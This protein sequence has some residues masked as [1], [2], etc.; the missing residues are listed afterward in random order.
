MFTLGY[1]RNH[2]K[3]NILGIQA[4]NEKSLW[5]Q[6]YENLTDDLFFFAEDVFG[7]QFAIRN[8][9]IVSFD[10]ESGQ[11][12]LLAQSLEGWAA[13]LLVNYPRLTGYPLAHSWQVSNGPIPVGKVAIAENPV[14]SRWAL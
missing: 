14:H 10:P 13:Q 9:D 6:W 3:L 12:E 8:D 7:G 1:L 2:N 5:R 11:I 4:W